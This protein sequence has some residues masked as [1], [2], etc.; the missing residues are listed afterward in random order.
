MDY[1]DGTPLVRHQVIVFR[2][3]TDVFVCVCRYAAAEGGL[4]T[5]QN[6]DSDQGGA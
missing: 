3:P 5:L 2:S 1:S 4:K 6:S